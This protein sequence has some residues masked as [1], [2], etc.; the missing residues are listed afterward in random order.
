MTPINRYIDNNDVIPKPSLVGSYCKSWAILLMI[1]I[2]MAPPQDLD[3]ESVELISLSSRD[4]P[5]LANVW[6]I[7]KCGLHHLNANAQQNYLSTL[8]GPQAC[9]SGRWS[10]EGGV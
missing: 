3:R 5:R 1:L 9:G 7:N 4:P 10:G 2:Y 8:H 6:A